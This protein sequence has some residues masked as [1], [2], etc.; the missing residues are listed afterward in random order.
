[1]IEQLR[2]YLA[3]LKIK[4][5]PINGFIPASVVLPIFWFNNEYFILFSKRAE[6]V[7]YHKGQ[8]SFP[9]G[10]YENG[11]ASALDTALREFDEELGIQ[12]KDIVILG[13]LDDC[14]TTVSS[15]VI[16]VFVGL[17]PYPYNFKIATDEIERIFKVPVSLLLDKKYQFEKPE[18]LSSRVRP[19][20]RFGDQVIW[21]ATA[22]ILTQFLGIWE[23]LSNLTKQC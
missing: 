14:I 1:M 20:F 10:R 12:R 11:D 16:S 3:A 22:R 5:I 6:T 8:I 7:T 21:G 4:Y 9:G 13:Q 17:I 19:V 23:E 15:Y 18:I 2:Q